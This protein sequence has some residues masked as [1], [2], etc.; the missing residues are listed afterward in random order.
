MVV[1]EE[2]PL[3]QLR[4]L[5]AEPPYLLAG[6]AGRVAEWRFRQ[7]RRESSAGP[8]ECRQRDQSLASSGPKATEWRVS[9]PRGTAGLGLKL[10]FEKLKVAGSGQVVIVAVHGCASRLPQGN[11]PFLTACR[12]VTKY[13]SGR[14]SPNAAAAGGPRPARALCRNSPSKRSR[15]FNSAFSMRSLWHSFRGPRQRRGARAERRAVTG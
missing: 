8:T 10:P 2:E 12:K 6:R 14:A 9:N 13:S 1:G 7:H 15:F 4:V 3:L 11:H 5:D